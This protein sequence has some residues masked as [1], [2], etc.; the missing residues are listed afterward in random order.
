MED[1]E[2]LIKD[3]VL[4]KIDG[5]IIHFIIDENARPYWSKTLNQYLTINKVDLKM[6]ERYKEQKIVMT[7]DNKHR[8]FVD[9]VAAIRGVKVD[10]ASG[11]SGYFSPMVDALTENDIF[12]V[13][14]A[15]PIV[16]D[17]HAAACSRDNCFVFDM[18]L[19][20]ELPF[21]DE[22]VDVFSGNFLNNVNN[23]A[24]LIREAYRCLRPGG[25]LAVI[26]M[27]FEHGCKTYEHLNE[28]GAIWSSFEVFVAFCKNVGFQYL[29]SDILHTRKG[30]I[31]D[32]DLYPLDENDCSADRAVYFEK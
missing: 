26:E 31:S 25:R 21:K 32:G 30:K 4:Y 14:D 16:V 9:F 15:C 1:I 11:P 17:A 23:Y 7:K 10:L 2:S 29:G 3:T 18:D 13:T 12:I 24:G 22:S 6:P 8:R 28:E 5:N 19:D 27:F 20:K